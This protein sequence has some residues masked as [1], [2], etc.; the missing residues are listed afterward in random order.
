MGTKF[1]S[2]SLSHDDAAGTMRRKQKLILTGPKE[3]ELETDLSFRSLRV[4]SST[5]LNGET[6][7][8]ILKIKAQP[9][10]KKILE[11]P[12]LPALPRKA[13]PL[14]TDFKEFH[15]DT[16]ARA[17]QNAEAS[18]VSYSESSQTKQ[19]PLC[20][21]HPT[22]RES[23]VLQ[24]SPRPRLPSARNP[25]KPEKEELQLTPKFK[26][27]P[28]NKKAPFSTLTSLLILEKKITI[29]QEFHFAIDE[30]IP[31]SI[32]LAEMFDELSVKPKSQQDKPIPRNTTQPFQLRTEERGAEKGKKWVSE[33]LHQQEQQHSRIPKANPYPYSTEYHVIPPKPEPKPCTKPKPFYLE[34]L[35]R[36]EEEVRRRL[37]E[38]WQM[39]MKD[40]QMKSFKAQPIMKEDPIPLPEKASAPLTIV[41][42]FSLHVQHRASGRAKFDKK[43][44]QKELM[45]KRRR[46]K[47]ESD[48]QR[49]EERNLKERRRTLIPHARQVPNFAHPFL[50]H[51]SSKQVTKPKSPR[52]N[53]LKVKEK[54]KI[55]ASPV[56][57]LTFISATLTSEI[58]ENSPTV[59]AGGV[60]SCENAALGR[61]ETSNEE[62]DYV[63]KAAY[64]TPAC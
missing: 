43:I 6:M 29:P 31:P 33:V 21:A 2:S 44:E 36:H 51:K 48:K 18:L 53:V 41:K 42:E 34:S 26:A 20:K 47:V 27:R 16:M 45:Y 3:P 23:S 13:T 14:T 35:V 60:I 37:Q 58:G 15:L 49:E 38:R 59:T 50:P 62:K 28:L 1:M 10:N 17:N 19:S 32:F 12:T 39:V 9:L 63:P 11:V 56:E 61:K 25:D 30:R 22:A 55:M 8:R 64:A 57:T 7:A 52:L 4:K 5:E 24:T 40:A 54:R 46:E